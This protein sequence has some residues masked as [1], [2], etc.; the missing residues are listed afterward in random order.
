[1]RKVGLI[2]IFIA[3][4]GAQSVLAF[5][6]LHMLAIRITDLRP[7]YVVTQELSP[8]GYLSKTWI[9]YEYNLSTDQLTTHSWQNAYAVGYRRGTIDLGNEIDEFLTP[10]GARWFYGVEYGTE[11]GPS[12]HGIAGPRIG[13]QSVRYAHSDPTGY[14]GILFQQGRYVVRVDT[15]GRARTRPSLLPLAQLVDARIRKAG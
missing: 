12:Y 11:F 8:N 10:R 13:D 9:A 14:I 1:M 4:L 5:M 2:G 3:A 15:V 6:P 7:G